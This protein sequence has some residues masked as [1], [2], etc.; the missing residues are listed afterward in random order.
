MP[1]LEKNV[2]FHS[3]YVLEKKMGAGGF[4]EV[5]LAH[6]NK[7]DIDVALK[8][9]SPD[10]GMDEKGI[11]IFSKE[12]SLVFNLN[13]ANLLKPSHF[14]DFDGSPYLVMPFC[15]NGSALDQIGEMDE[16][17]LAKFMSNA[18]AALDYLHDQNPPIIH[19]DIKP[20]NFLID[21]KGHYLLSDFGISSRIKRVLTRS[22]GRQN[23]SG[24]LPYMPPEKFV[25]DRQIIKASDIFSL[26]VTFYEL[27]TGELPF[28]E[29]GGLLLNTGAEIPDLPSKFSAEL[30]TLIG[31]CLAKEPWNRPVA[32]LLMEIG[33]E[34]VK[35]GRWNL[36]GLPKEEA[37]EEKAAETEKAE[38]KPSKKEGRKTEQYIFNE[39]A[40]SKTEDIKT[41]PVKESKP[42]DK[43]K[44]SP[45]LIVIAILV[46]A[47]IA[48]AIYF[49]NKPVEKVKTQ[50]TSKDSLL[51][52]NAKKAKEDS[53]KNK[54]EE[55]RKKDSLKAV[56]DK[57]KVVDKTRP[58]V[59]NA[60]ELAEIYCGGETLYI[61][62]SNN[63]GNTNW[64]TAMA[65]CRNLT[66]YG[67]TDWYLPS[68]TELNC[69]FD[70]QAKIGGFGNH[71]FWSSTGNTE[72]AW[73]Q[74][75]YDGKQFNNDKE[76][77]AFVRCIRK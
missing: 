16:K 45:A 71:E 21:D 24:T 62:P 44:I 27:L 52:A 37:K 75:F 43:K 72:Y 10:K 18:A 11:E 28:G 40:P 17:E 53:I 32:A 60:V 22:V 68:R 6:D 46:I 50:S 3:R 65:I 76:D 67:F 31:A 57:N 4:S 59:E 8:V 12:Y 47:G 74:N 69:L 36:S 20:D 29:H 1:R 63:S 14:D 49:A 66:A 41:I 54:Q 42:K 73:I 51:L 77:N 55:K 48:A 2:V 33:D 61:Y 19:Q 7:A 64:S 25:K 26:G 56:T 5:W 38:E 23:S 15:K 34:Y 30:N 58:I 9:F 39:T 70:A 13:N 35:T